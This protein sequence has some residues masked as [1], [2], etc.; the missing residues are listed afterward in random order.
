MTDFEVAVYLP[1]D[2]AHAERMCQGIP[3]GGSFPDDP[4]RYTRPVPPE[5]SS[6]RPHCPF[7]LDVWQLGTSF[8]EFKVGA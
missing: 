4:A 2:L 8:S 3:S 1:H 5:V 7:K 6:G